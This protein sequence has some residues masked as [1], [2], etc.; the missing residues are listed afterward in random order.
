MK[1]KVSMVFFFSTFKSQFIRKKENL[2]SLPCHWVLFFIYFLI[3]YQNTHGMK[4]KAHI[5]KKKKKQTNINLT[6]RKN[7]LY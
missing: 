4:K 1:N 5:K 2:F 6:K 7:G 3:K